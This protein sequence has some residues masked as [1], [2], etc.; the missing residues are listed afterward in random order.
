MA[1]AQTGDKQAYATLLR[2][3]APFARRIAARYLGPADAEDAVQEILIALH[4]VR[5]TYDPARPFRPW[6]ATL[7]SRRIIDALRRRGRRHAQEVEVGDEIA[8]LV[9]GD[10]NPAT[11][12]ARVVDIREVRAAV[13]ELPRRQREAV[14]LLRLQEMSL[15]EASRASGQTTGSLKVALHRAMRSLRGLL[16][17]RG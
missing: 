2:E 5:H 10:D 12:A 4:A 16:E 9:S 3:V 1:A 6:L 7:A 8:A 11:L 14:E 15:E 17:G 13:A